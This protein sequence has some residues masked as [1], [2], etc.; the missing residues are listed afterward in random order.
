MIGGR[1]D[2]E[3]LALCLAV[4]DSV[5]QRRRRV[6]ERFIIEVTAITKRT[7]GKSVAQIVPHFFE[8]WSRLLVDSFFA[9][10]VAVQIYE[11]K[12][13]V[14]AEKS[15]PLRELVF[16]AEIAGMILGDVDAV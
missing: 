15:V 2:V 3:Q 5:N 6:G 11:S 14:F 9:A 4:C 1:F 16:R 12:A 10:R 7:A 8:R 13:K